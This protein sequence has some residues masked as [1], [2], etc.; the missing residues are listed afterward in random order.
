MTIDCQSRGRA[1]MRRFVGPLLA[2]F[3]VVVSSTAAAQ[4]PAACKSPNPA[5]WPP[6]SK[7][8][9]MIVVDTSGSMDSN[10]ATP[11]SCNYHVFNDPNGGRID[12]ARCAVK[13]TV[14]AFSEVNFGLASYARTISNCNSNGTC[15][16][17]C[18]YGNF[19]RSA[20]QNGGCPNDN[21]CGNKYNNLAANR[22]GANILSPMLLDAYWSPPPPP[23]NVLTIAGYA[24]NNCNGSTELFA[25]GCT[26]LNGA[27]RD[28]YRY[29]Q[30]GW[31]PQPKTCAAVADCNGTGYTKCQADLVGNSCGC[32]NDADCTGVAAFANAGRTKC[33][34]LPDG[35]KGCGFPSPIGTAAQGERPC[36]SI[37]VIL[38]TDGDETCDAQAD[39]VS[40]AGALFSGV[41]I[42]N[43]SDAGTTLWKI[44]THVINFAGASKTDTDA[45]AASGGTTSS[46]VAN[47]EADLSAALANIVGSA[48][49]PEVCDNTDNN[50]NGCTDEGTPHFCNQAQTCCVWNN[51]GERD[52]C[53][54]QYQASINPDAG[55]AQGDLKLLPCTTPGQQ[56]NDPKHWLCYDPKDGCEDPGVDN[57]CNGTVDENVKRC[58]N[59]AHCATPETCNGQ[60]DNCDGIVDNAPGS[61][62]PYSLP[63]CTTC[64]PSEEICDGCDN[65]CDGIADNGVAALPCGIPAGPGEPAYCQG[66]QTCKAAQ[67]VAKAGACLPNAPGNF[68]NACNVVGQSEI[69][70]TLDDDCN[71]IIDDGI[72]PTTCDVPG[73]PGLD[74]GPKSVCKRGQQPCGGTCTGWV[75]PADGEICDGMD[76]DCNGLVDDNVVTGVG[77][78]CGSAIPPC[79]KGTTA[80]IDGALQCSGG[81]REK[82][83]TCNGVDDDCNGT[84][85]D[86]LTDAPTGTEKNCWPLPGSSCN[87]KG[88]VSWD[89]PP[90]GTCTGV[91]TL[92]NPCQTGQLACVQGAWKCLGGTLPGDEVCDGA[93]NDCDNQTDEG[94][95]PEPC[96][97][98]VGECKQGT[99]SCT[100]GKIVCNDEV[101]PSDEKCDGKDNDCNHLV[102]DGLPINVNDKCNPTFDTVQFPHTPVDMIQSGAIGECKLGVA[103]CVGDGGFA[104]IDAVGPT[105]EVCDLK[106][107]DCDGMT[108]EIET[109]D[110][111]QGTANPLDPSQVIGQPC[112]SSVGACRPGVWTC[113]LGTVQ[114]IGGR[115]PQPELCDCED[116]DCDGKVDEDDADAG[117][118]PICG[119]STGSVCVSYKGTCQCAEPCRSGEFDTCPAGPFTCDQ[120][121][122]SG[123]GDNVGLRC[124]QDPATFCGDCS[125]KTVGVKLEAGFQVE[126]APA[127][128]IDA[129]TYPVC[130]CK[131]QQGCH[132]PCSGITCTSD[133]GTSIL[134]TDFGPNAGRCVADNCFNIPCAAGKLCAN[135]TCLN[136]P[137]M[138][139][140]CAANEVC[141][142]SADFL[143]AT[144][145]K[146]CASV[147]C[148]TGQVCSHGSCAAPPCGGACGSGQVCASGGGDA[149]AEAGTDAGAACVADKCSAQGGCP[150]GGCCNPVTGACGTC[151]CTGVHCPAGQTC[152]ADECVVPTADA[153]SDAPVAMTDGAVHES[154]AGG[155][156]G[157]AGAA[158]EPESTPL[159]RFGLA[160]GGGG[161]QCELGR[162]PSS[163]SA[164]LVALGAVVLG[165]GRRRRRKPDVQ[166]RRGTPVGGAQ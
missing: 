93:D 11:N 2:L 58:G 116:N 61:S 130:V 144:C 5:S 19:P 29:F 14:Q 163:G 110:G 42:A 55:A 45:I 88:K 95:V 114:C 127:G 151:P 48:I 28:M 99:T 132:S 165:V 124:V 133:A 54:A 96:G 60:D 101:G 44:R 23:S 50:C 120:V 4:E 41:S 73:K 162:R 148:S 52:T 156:G 103:Q 10:V 85:D 105:Q 16:S 21:G 145:E 92:T 1:V 138:G 125:K 68:R 15:Y 56:Q 62:T 79:T 31:A 159:G 155:A 118:P 158:G 100:A 24:D 161:C 7:P 126:C 46:Y 9:F 86:N 164:W 51:D 84:P 80:C 140:G 74:Y 38:L 26:P 141:R 154:G 111:I 153:G 53:L 157:A 119:S 70:N 134:C 94:F 3:G 33:V 63:N 136:D 43:G 67:A 30:G 49:R 34:T 36:R 27:L 57:N 91:G 59:P 71:G 166:P 147:T 143:T 75:G 17:N 6:P 160:T 65:D 122:R 131:G 149:G 89:P 112:G 35:A 123:T 66:Q 108:D 76:N 90:N 128:A 142:P 129:G 12:H 150:N 81:T 39:A 135:F 106:D 8:Y 107:N 152:V 146:S 69:C 20:P 37:N 22:Q 64:V 25:D 47:D 72:A 115:G 87:Y 32:A 121:M 82:P 97:S 113:V 18:T 102:D 137:C 98:N 117:A 13:K 139:K 83:E 104:C 78:Q 40:A 77:N 109:P